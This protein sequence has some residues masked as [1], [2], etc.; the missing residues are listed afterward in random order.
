ML[1]DI[2]NFF[3]GYVLIGV[4]GFSVERFV[5]LAT[6]NGI[7]LWDIKRNSDGVILKVSVKGFKMLKKYARK[8]G[9][10][11]KILN[12]RGLPFKIYRYKKRKIFAG[13]LIFFVFS[14]YLLSSFIWLINIEGNDRINSEDLLRF[15]QQQNFKI[16][17]FKPKINFKLLEQ[18]LLNSFSDISWINIK[19]NGTRAIIQLKETIPK[20]KIVDR[21]TPC[22]IIAKKDGLILNATVSSGTPKIKQKDVVKKGDILVSGEVVIENNNLESS[23]PVTEYVHAKAKVKAKTYYQINFKIP[24][25]YIEKRYTGKTQKSYTIDVFNKKLSFFSGTK[26]INYDRIST[27]KQLKLTNNYPLPVKIFVNEY[28]EFMPVKKKRS[29]E[30]SKELADKIVTGRIIR[31]FDFDTDIYD[32]QFKFMD[33][34]KYLNVETVIST[35]EFI[36]EQAEME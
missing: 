16:G 13:G 33:N 21:N 25:E 7:Y 2:C 12:K 36:D 23:E 27:E 20:Q 19:V 28:K 1:L 26:Y 4:K 10:R 5:N 22:N 34:G 29:V 14:L 3:K 24:Y 18:K 30:Q 6:Y 17:S 32:K 31:E 15:C 35:V 8:T 9:C 11:I